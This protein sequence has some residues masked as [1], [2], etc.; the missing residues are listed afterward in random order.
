MKLA[1]VLTVLALA[2]WLG[3]LVTLGA[4]VAPI[5][6]GVV[7]A[8]SSADAMT[9]VFRRFDRVALVCAAVVA[10]A[11]VIRA[12]GTPSISRFDLARTSAGVLAGLL[13]TIEAAWVSPE[14]ASL[15]HQGAVRGSGALGEALERAHHLA[16]LLAKAELAL[17]VVF[18]VLL[19]LSEDRGRSG[20][21]RQ[22]DATP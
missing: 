16:E 18:A 11:E 12:R 3:G 7:P 6:F 13:R 14:I 10:L 19:A 2:V 4:L 21:S 9:L 15:H 22:D 20:N 8:P 17:L 5:V 1:R